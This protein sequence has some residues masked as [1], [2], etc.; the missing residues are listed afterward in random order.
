[1]NEEHIERIYARLEKQ[2]KVLDS[3]HVALVGNE[4]L[5]HKGLVPR[6]ASLEGQVSGH[7]K[8]L[9]LAGGIII[10]AQAALSLIK[11]KLFGA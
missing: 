2:D 8:K 9:I 4:H 5:G 10:G 1:M 6:V 3:I 11:T 7:D